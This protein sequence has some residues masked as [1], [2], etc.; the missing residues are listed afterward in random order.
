MA[1]PLRQYYPINRAAELLGCNVGDLLHWASVGG[2]DLYISIEHGT[3][4][5]YFKNGEDELKDKYTYEL[6]V[7]DDFSI[8]TNAFN[9]IDFDINRPSK[10]A[11]P[12]SF[13]GLWSLP[14][15]VFGIGVLYEYQPALLDVWFSFNK[16]M[17]ITFETSES[18]D[19][20]IEDLYITKNDFLSIKRCNEDDE[21]PNYINERREKL[22]LSFDEG[23]VKQERVS[24][25]MKNAIRIMARK[26]YPN[27]YASPTNLANSLTADAE[28]QGLNGIRFDGST[29]GRW[30]KD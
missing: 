26:T 8:V 20:N 6:V 21:L 30:L 1:M 24:G 9:N 25:A 29:V 11:L 28:E 17:F 22:T 19:F 2:I 16:K 13:S 27:V 3:G 7:K 5:V 10:N 15:N 23:M 14:W 18:I 12:C 4:Y